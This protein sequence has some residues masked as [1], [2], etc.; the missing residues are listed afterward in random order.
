MDR[1]VVHTSGPDHTIALG[2][3]LGRCA[4]AGTVLALCGDLGSGKTQLARGLAAGLGVADQRVVSSPT[5]VLINEYAGRLA[6]FHVDAYRLS[7]GRELWALG[8][9][10]MCASGGVVVVEWADRV[11]GVLPA[12]HLRVDLRATG[13]TTR[14][15]TLSARG[16]HARGMLER[17]RMTQSSGGLPP[18]QTPGGA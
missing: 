4:E 1:L 7:S 11:G 17:F 12:D 8:F 5:Y 6:V 9:E 2:L 14:E 15:I 3:Q 10:E 13:E 16:P 18:E